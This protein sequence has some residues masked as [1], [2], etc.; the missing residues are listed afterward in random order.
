MH[1]LL[2]G[3]TEGWRRRRQLRALLRLTPSS[4]TVLDLTPEQVRAEGV[5]ALAVDFD[6]VLAPHGGEAPL[7]EAVVWLRSM[8]SALGEDKLVILSNR[9][10]GPRLDWFRQEMPGVR[11]LA[12]VRKKPYPDGLI[13]AGE[14][15]SAP[16][17]MILMVDDRLLTGCLAA[18]VAG[19]RP[20]YVRRPFVDWR[21]E[22]CHELFFM[23]LRRGERLLV[24]LFP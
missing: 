2:L 12:G 11:V 16:L 22:A 4:R 20:W 13:Q 3:L 24:R 5:V 14:Q 7:P 8:A 1:H 23:L 15:M 9:P 6:G 21:G 19:C 17:S 18:L 10:K